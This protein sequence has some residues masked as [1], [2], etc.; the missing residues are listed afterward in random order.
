VVWGNRLQDAIAHGIAEDNKW[1][2]RKKTEYMR[3][4]DIRMGASFDFE[5]NGEALLEIKNVDGLVFKNGWIADDEDN[6][7]APPHIELQ[8]QAQ[9]AV[10]G[11]KTAYVGAL[12]GGNRVILLKRE[13]D[14]KIIAQ[15]KTKIKDFWFNIENGN[16]PEPDF[17]KDA[18][19]ICKIYG[20]AE[21]GKIYDGRSNDHLRAL[22]DKYKEFSEKMEEAK[23]ERDAIK[24]QMLT[25]FGDAEKALGLG[26]TVSASM[27][28]PKE[29]SYMRSGYRNFRLNW[30]K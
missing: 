6:V 28:Q 5:I 15:L 20:Y 14:E 27:V 16:V 10:S 18:E 13:A 1:S 2:I 7:E 12:V 30:K 21:E 8:V 3:L 25:E 11:L 4:P 24:A 17:K 22:A 29:I 19:L 9:M 23:S 26:F